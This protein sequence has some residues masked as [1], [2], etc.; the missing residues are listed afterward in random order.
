MS[1]NLDAAQEA[2]QRGMRNRCVGVSAF[3]ARLHEE[4]QNRLV[5]TS[6]GSYSLKL[7]EWE[8]DPMARHRGPPGGPPPPFAL[9]GSA[10][11][12][13]SAGGEAF[14]PTVLFLH[15]FLGGPRDWTA[16]ASALSLSCRCLAVELPGHSRWPCNNL[17]PSAHL[18]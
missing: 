15:G 17:N 5:H 2:W 9:W 14:R 18:G 12:D 6:R 11:E 7:V 3:A 10:V 8:F 1:I 4:E 16:V 13:S